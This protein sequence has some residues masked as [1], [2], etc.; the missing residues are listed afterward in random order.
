VAEYEPR[1]LRIIAVHSRGSGN[2]VAEV[3]ERW[4][5]TYP[6]ADDRGGQTWEKYGVR[7]TPN[8]ALIAPDGS[9]SHRQVGLVTTDATRERIEGLLGS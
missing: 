1:G 5:I 7:A 2:P 8:Y 3:V 6:V 9:L 4:D